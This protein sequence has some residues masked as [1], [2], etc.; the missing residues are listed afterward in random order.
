MLTAK[1]PRP[2]PITT[3]LITTMIAAAANSPSSD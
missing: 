1:G 3:K 2:T